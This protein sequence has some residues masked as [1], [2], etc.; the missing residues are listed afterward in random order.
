MGCIL[1]Q[2]QAAEQVE[3]PP[4]LCYSIFMPIYE[5]KCQKCGTIESR[6][7]QF[8][9]SAWRMLRGILSLKCR[10]CGSRKLIRIFS[11]FAVDGRRSNADTLNELSKMGPV[12]FSPRPAGP[13][14]GKCPYHGDQT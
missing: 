11:N 1:P 10:T 3:I 7:E 4:S 8:T 2:P 12:T 13:P 6:L 5:Y 9:S 14:G